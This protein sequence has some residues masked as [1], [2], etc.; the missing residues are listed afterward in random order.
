[1]KRFLLHRKG[2]FA[3]LLALFLGMGTAYAFDFSEVY[4]G[5]TF[6]FQITDATN[7]YVK[8]TYPG[9]LNE[10][11]GGYVQPTGNIILPSTISHDG[12]NYTVTAIGDYAFFRCEDLTGSLTIPNTVTSI[13]EF[14][15]QICSG[16]NGSLNLGNSVT[17]IGPYAFMDCGFTGSLTLPNSLTSIGNIAFAYCDGF[18]GSLNIP[19][20]V[21]SIG[22]AAF[23][24]CTGFNGTLTIGTGLTSMGAS[25]FK[26]C[27]SF[28]HVNY[29]A[30][31]CANVTSAAK[32]FENCSG[33]LTIGNTVQRI[34]SYMF[35]DA[36]GLVGSLTIPNSVTDIG[37]CAFQACDG[38]TGSLTIGNSVT[39]IETGTFGWCP[40]FSGTLTIGSSVTT[41]EEFAF[42]E[43]SSFTGSL[44][45]PNSVTTIGDYA[46][47]GCGFTGSLTLGNSLTSIGYMAFHSCDGFTGSLTIP[48]SVTTI[49]EWAFYN[50]N[51]F[52]GSLTIPNSVTT[53]GKMTFCSCS[54][55]TGSLTIPNA[56]TSIGF[57]AF[58]DCSGFTNLNI[59]ASVNTIGESAFNYCTGLTSMVLYPETPP[60]LGTAFNDVPRNI[61]VRVPCGKVS[62]YQ[63]ASG[64]DEFTNIQEFCDPLTYSINPDGV[65]VTVTGHVDGTN[66]TGELFIPEIKVID[67]VAYTV[68]AIGN[69]AFSSCSGLT[70]SLIIPNTVTSIGEYAF[71]SCTGLT[72]NLILPNAL[73]T[74]GRYA[75]QNCPGFTGDLTLPNTLTTLGNGAFYLCDGFNGNL[76]LPNSIT[77]IGKDTF[78]SCKFIGSLTIPNT[79]NT[80]GDLAFYGCSGF[81]GTLTI[82]TGVTSIGSS[83]FYGC[84]H[85]THVNY[86]AVNCADINSLTAKPFEN[87]TGT[88]S[89]GNTVQRIPAYLFFEADGLTGSLTIPNSV[90]T[91]GS[92]AFAGCEGFTG[93]LTIGN[94]VTTIE[95]GGFGWCPN[96]TTLT[97]GS[98]LTTIGPQ[99]FYVD[100][101]F[102]G[103]LTIPNSVTYIGRCAFDFCNNFTGPLTI[104]NS[105]TC[106]ESMA[107][108]DCYGFTGALTI[109]TSL[110]ELGSG[111]FY[112]CTGFTQVNYNAINCAVVPFSDGSYSSP[113]ESCEGTLNIGSNV[114]RIPAYLFKDCTGFTGSLYIPSSVTEVGANA[115]DNCTGFTGSLILG[116][117]LTTIGDYAFYG[118]HFTGSLTI[119]DSVTSLGEYAFA[120]CQSFTEL[121]INNSVTSIGNYSFYYCINLAYLTV[122]PE[123]PPTMGN[124]AFESVPTD[125]PVYVPCGSIS[126]YQEASGWSTFTNYQCIPW[127]V[128]LSANPWDGGTVSGEGT[129]A[130]GAS[131]TVTATPNDDYLF[132]HW[133]SNGEVVSCNASYTFTVTQD[134]ELEAV[135]M[136]LDNEGTIIGSGENTNVYLPSYSLYNYCLSQQIYTASELG[137]SFTINSISF[138]N[139]GNEETRR[140]DV[141]LV[142]TSKSSFSSGTD[143]IPVYQADCVY[144]GLVT[145]RKGMWTTIVLDTPFNYNGTSN[146]A[147]IMDDN[148]G[149][150]TYSPHMA[151]R[152]Y[153]APQSNQAMRI[154][155]D[156]TN[157][158]AN[159]PSSYTGTR[160]SV[161]NQIMF[162]RPVYTITA[163]PNNASMGTV[164]GAGQYGYGDLCRVKAT[165]N[166]GYT[167]LDWM[168]INGVAATD[169]AEYEFFVTGDRTLRANFFEGTD[170]CN[171]TFNLDN[172]DQGWGSN[173]LEV[174]FGNGMSHLFGV[175]NDE[176]FATYTLPF[177]NGNHVELN[178]QNGSFSDQCPFE[179]RYANGNLACTS[180]AIIGES[181]YDFDI[182]CDDMLANW[183]Y[184]GDGDDL[185][186]VYLP[187]YSYYKH[188]LSQQIYTAA[189]FGSAGNITSIAFYNQGNNNTKTRTYDIYLKPTNKFEFVNEHDW[190]SVSEED[191]VFSGDVTLTTNE[192]TFITFDKPFVYDGTSN[193]VLVM[194][195]NSGNYTNAPH[196]AC[197]VYQTGLDQA[198]RVYSDGTNYDPFAPTSY[199]G[200]VMDMKNQVYFGF[201]NI[202]CW[203]PANLTATD[204][205]T[206]S[207][208]LHWEGYQ[209][210]YNV[211]YR[212]APPFYEDFE[213]EESFY[214]DWTFISMNNANDIGVNVNSAG[215][216]TDAAHSDEYGFRFS[217]YYSAG[218]YN[219]YLVSPILDVTGELK[220]YYKQSNNVNTETFKV[221]YSTT[222]NVLDAFVWTDLTLTSSWQEYTLQLPSNVKYIAFHYYGNYAWYVYL[223]DITIGGNGIPMGDWETVNNVAGTTIEISGLDP[224]TNYV[225]QVQGNNANCNDNGSTRWSKKATFITQC[226]AFIV[227]AENPFIEDFEDEAF[228]PN[229][230]E[231]YSTNSRQWTRSTANA[232]SGSASAYSSYYGDVYL[233]M[234]DLELSDNA[235]AAQLSFWSYDSYPDDFAPGNNSV[236]LLDGDTETVLWS[237]E[238]ASQVWTE[239]TIDLSA[240]LGQTI[241]LAFKYAGYDGNGWHVDDVEVSVT[242][243]STITQTIELVEGWNWV[244]L[245]IEKEDPVELLVMLESALG[246]NGLQIESQY[247]GLTEKIGDGYWWGDLDE[248]GVMNESMYLIEV[249]ADCTV[250]LEGTAVDPADY[251]IILYPEW[252]WIGF[253]C[254]EEVDIVIALS[255]LEAEEGDMIE[256]ADGVAE[257]LGGGFWYGIETLVPGQGYMYYSAS[258]EQKTLIIQRGRSKAK[259]KADAQN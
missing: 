233:V 174:H 35:N 226:N 54:S 33:T 197:R 66:A 52:T 70:G 41:I 199:S 183:A 175:L 236:V 248:V 40:N 229:C 74:I 224:S 86:N 121:I 189:E 196:M 205:S 186:N 130:N 231:T 123:I 94:S 48:N 8:L 116:N 188:G 85:F 152:V 194:D 115:F 109:G 11:W 119:P 131:C 36:D 83:A 242:P 100:T 214:A 61:L 64:W 158:A 198:I 34:P 200:T 50:C 165:A 211:R 104:P 76:T 80:I 192:W 60:T 28:T 187:S 114:Q 98:S 106:I 240:Y 29:N 177:V 159:N 201:A 153:N 142:H 49:E 208:T 169:E 55:F 156:G 237:A 250:E 141:Y 154:Y 75:F 219:Q 209:D 79:V 87:C 178:M 256:G 173:Y 160:L 7:H 167:F 172:Y 182:D 12:T 151:C 96:F 195:D 44:T 155:S 65:S 161:K 90:T 164:S 92:C 227:D 63:S 26:N 68:T 138:F 254:T 239:A 255:G 253:P 117:S 112:N 257:Y 84:N 107:F 24:G 23:V 45:I 73:N 30:V 185:T 249:A 103:T 78:T 56:V 18:T 128:T 212:V 218:D 206:N 125:I 81:D 247:D 193:I 127:T 217:S 71:S 171:L 146:L 15:F 245:Y 5:N 9:T 25:A 243:A 145:M 4:S 140:Y 190:I 184:L 129:Y 27:S 53:I 31:N 43:D 10:P 37:Y 149:D 38:F 126:D 22:E 14:A 39:T 230:W 180:D 150:F 234:P 82:G 110:T 67:G 62:A 19:N 139:A 203:P 77:A 59:G 72:G 122:R 181:S 101:G 163:T 215:L 46:F 20:S 148:T 6:Y 93:S 221:G 42:Y 204:I 124:S 58:T 2:V 47:S 223:D 238:T 133:R 251:E 89:I 166:S 143:W 244:S 210:S 97:L 135:F 220:F 168:D 252:T 235:S 102:T 202:D 228:V 232:Y 16:L 176:G 13:G 57:Q 241:T 1:M 32:P 113:F 144:S 99:A 179:V 246:E 132:M 95:F 134:V 3:L 259:A 120:W 51:G 157:Y 147:L 108:Q 136:P 105:V 216:H 258:G 69:N 17:E 213:D 111:A 91:I 207:A 137:G 88:I 191:K 170:V 225:W 21:T 118:M 222:S 162:N